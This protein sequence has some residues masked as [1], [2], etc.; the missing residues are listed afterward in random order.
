MMKM[1]FGYVAA[2][3]FASLTCL[4]SLNAQVNFKIA[5]RTVQVHSFA[6]QGFTYSNN[7]N[8]LT[9]NTSA[10]SFAMTDGGFN[11]AS[12]ITDKFRAG[13]QFYIRNI[14][15]LGDWTPEMDWGYGD[16]RFARWLGVRGGKVKTS[17]GLYTDTQDM[18]FLQTWAIMPQS[19]YPTDLRGNTIAHVGG[20][21]YGKTGLK[22]LGSV[23]YTAYGGQR[24]SDM[25]GGISYGLLGAG[26]VLNSYGGTLWGGDTRW[27]TPVKGLMLGASYISISYKENGT[28]QP[29]K[30]TG[31]KYLP[32][33]VTSTKDHIPVYYGEY[34][35]WN[36]RFDGEYRREILDVFRNG[37]GAAG[38]T[39]NALATDARSGFISGAWRVN[40]WVEVGTYHSRFYPNFPTPFR[41]LQA[42]HIFDQTVTARVDVTRN[43]D[44]KIEGHFMDGTAGP[45]SYHG[46][47]TL[48][49]TG[50]LQ[51]Q[52][53]LFVTRAEVHF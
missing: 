13:G 42:N 29:T 36:L 9:M 33:T 43:L 7:N 30:A 16:Y 40:R 50:G 2:G 52:T 23:A 44:V 53:K 51:P 20:D 10:G 32:Y 4:S 17:L 5:D 27:T 11:V 1:Y 24:P 15:V 21:L 38:T 34:T 22:K 18:T 37:A 39:N 46:F 28:R 25:E 12:Q 3:I 19:T 41:S 48:D 8:F 47:Y 45:N 31:Y 49:N 6:S 14:G 35:I 26:I